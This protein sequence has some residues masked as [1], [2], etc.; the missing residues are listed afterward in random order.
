LSNWLDPSATGVTEIDGRGLCTPPTFDFTLS[1]NPATAG[2]LVTFDAI[3]V[4]GTGPFEYAWDFDGDNV[5]DCTTDPCTHTYSAYY[6]GNVILTV[7]DVGESCAGSLSKAMVVNAPSVEYLSTGVPYEVCGDADGIIEP[8]EEWA[9]PVTVTN[10]GNM[11]G[12]NVM[13]TVS[14]FGA[15]LDV[16]MTAGMLD[17]GSVPAGADATTDFSFGID[18]AFGP[19]GAGI[20]FDLGT[21]T[22]TGGSNPGSADIFT[23]ATGGGTGTQVALGDDFEDAGTWHGLGDPTAITDKWVVTTG[24][25]PHTGGEWVRAADTYSQGQPAGSTGYFAIADSDEAGS[26]STTSTILWSPLVDLS[27][28]LSGTVTLSF[29]GFYNDYSG[30]EYADVDVWDGSTWQN[31]AHWAGADIDDRHSID[32]STHAL[33]NADLRVRFS[34]QDAAFDWWFSI[35]NFEVIVP[36]DTVCDNAE[37]CD[38][39]G[40]LFSDG[41]ESGDTSLWSVTI[42]IP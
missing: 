4:V 42:P 13:A 33:G 28:V 1:P 21:M 32:I 3:S 34:Y 39:G 30:S 17:F 6:N 8:G 26:G 38:F 25:G 23:A 29:D 24:P 31:V 12:T 35:D 11:A 7:T 10:V 18:P 15:P 40:E 20:Q 14:V 19:C 27:A 2:Q 36:I 5:T 16:V 41:F 37:S 22:W 9:V